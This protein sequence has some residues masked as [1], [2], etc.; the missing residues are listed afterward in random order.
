MIIVTGDVK[1]D[2]R[3]MIIAI[4]GHRLYETV[5]ENWVKPFNT[6]CVFYGIIYKFESLTILNPFEKFSFELE[7]LLEDKQMS[8][9]GKLITI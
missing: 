1:F 2:N 6:L 9:V 7:N 3:R 4:V 8:S 5:T